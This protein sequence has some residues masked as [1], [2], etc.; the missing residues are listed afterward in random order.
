[1]TYTPYVS[2]KMGDKGEGGV[3]YLKKRVTSFKDCP[4]LWQY[5]LTHRTFLFCFCFPIGHRNVFVGIHVPGEKSHGNHHGNHHGSHH[6]SHHHKNR[7][8][9]RRRHH[10]KKSPSEPMRPGKIFG[11][12]LCFL[13]ICVIKPKPL[14]F[15]KVHIII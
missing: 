4:L 14:F 2:S 6:G 7:F 5:I 10:Q 13:A 12:F 3:K 8:H 9:H 11:F 15:L 1:M